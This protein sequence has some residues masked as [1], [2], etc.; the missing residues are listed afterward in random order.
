MEDLLTPIEVEEQAKSAGWTMAE[1]CR[2]AGV[3]QSTFT[4]WKNGTTCPSVDVALR[5]RDAARA[6]RAA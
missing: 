5:L 1:V 2:I 6:A 3:A 4:R